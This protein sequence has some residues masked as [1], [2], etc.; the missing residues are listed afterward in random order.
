MIRDYISVFTIE[1]SMLIE[2][3]NLNVNNINQI[4]IVVGGYHSQDLFRFPMKLIY[5][6]GNGEIFERVTNIGY[7]PCR[8]YY[9]SIFKNTII[10]KVIN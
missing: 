4:D 2:Y 7:I 9:C 1:T 5:V 8:K 3:F 6:M 10:I